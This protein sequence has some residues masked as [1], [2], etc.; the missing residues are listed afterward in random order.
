MRKRC[1]LSLYYALSACLQ[2][3]VQLPVGYQMYRCMLIDKELANTLVMLLW[4]VGVA[5]VCGST[6][7]HL[8]TST[9]GIHCVIRWVVIC[10]VG[11]RVDLRCLSCGFPGSWIGG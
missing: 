4:R 3:I 11:G 2:C 8:L 5:M 9:R 7:V 10:R 6:W 1:G